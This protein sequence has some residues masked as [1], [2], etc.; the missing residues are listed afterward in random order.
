MKKL[1][2]SLLVL[3]WVG[4]VSLLLGILHSWHQADLR[5]IKTDIPGLRSLLAQSLSDF[6][7]VHFFTPTC[8][9]SQVVMAQLL[10]R[11]PLSANGQAEVVV[12]LDDHGQEAARQLREHG[13]QVLHLASPESGGEASSLVSAVPLLVV[14]DGSGDVLYAGGYS[15]RT[16]TPFSQLDLQEMIVRI[17]SGDMP[18][19]LPVRGCAVSRAYQEILDPLGL[20][21]G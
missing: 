11:Q 3:G 1:T 5:P 12:L 2:L 16:I 14:F 9:C 7:V 17:N 21:Y 6:N 19:P 13:Y 4:A 18:A 10:E 20:K 15:D 8:S